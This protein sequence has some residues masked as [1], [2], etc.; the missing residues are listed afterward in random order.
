[1]CIDHPIKFVVLILL[2]VQCA[3]L[4]SIPKTDTS[5]RAVT[6]SD[7]KDYKA[8]LS[9]TLSLLSFQGT[10]TTS[11]TANEIWKKSPP[12]E[13]PDLDK[14]GIAVSIK[15]DGVRWY[16]RYHTDSRLA[17]GQ[18]DSFDGKL[19]YIRKPAR[20]DRLAQLLISNV[21]IS[22]ITGL[23]LNPIRSVV[24]QA[25]LL[26]V[27][28]IFDL[29]LVRTNSG[30][31]D[32]I[33]ISTQDLS[34]V[35]SFVNLRSGL[36]IKSLDIIRSNSTKSFECEWSESQDSKPVL[37][38][39]KVKTLYENGAESVENFRYDIEDIAE[40]PDYR[41]LVTEKTRLVDMRKNPNRIR[42]VENEAGFLDFMT[43]VS[44]D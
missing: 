34:F 28:G 41:A 8:A 25:K 4:W 10:L 2:S 21:S 42:V 12:V 43:N 6:L 13:L 37:K 3:S 38:N 22:P 40:A 44:Q 24:D 16:I 14:P 15:S 11:V 1:M 17:A 26:D 23:V 9:S 31:P 27:D 36:V 5:L 19:F 20:N 33:N 35:I 30:F 29:H 32:T 39:I 7:I 18:I